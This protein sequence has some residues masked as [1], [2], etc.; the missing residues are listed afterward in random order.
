MNRAHKD[1]LVASSLCLK[2][3]KIREFVGI[4]VEVTESENLKSLVEVTESDNLKS[5]VE[6]DMDEQ[7]VDMDYTSIKMLLLIMS[8]LEENPGPASENASFVG[9]KELED[10]E[11]SEIKDEEVSVLKNKRSKCAVCGIGDLRPVL[12]EKGRQK[13]I[14]YTRNGM[15]KVTHQVMRCNNRNPECRAFHGFGFYQSKKHRIYENDALKNDVLVIS[16]QTGFAMDYLVEIAAA[17]EINADPF[18][19]LSKVYNRMH[20]NKLPTSTADRRIDLYQKRLTEAYFLYIYLELSQRYELPNHQVLENSNLDKTIMKHLQQLHK[21]FRNKW[22]KN[23]CDQKGCGW[24][25]TVDGGLKPHRMVCGAKLSG[26]REF[27]KAGIKVITGCTKHPAFNSKYCQEHQTE[28]SPAVTSDMISSRTRQQLRKHRTD[29]AI[30]SEAK[31]DDVFIVES[32]LE[33]K[34]EAKKVL[35]KWMGF[36][37][38]TWENEKGIPLFIRDYYEKDATRLGRYFLPHIYH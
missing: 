34:K 37:D 13:M 10:W 2:T 29:T 4:L 35:V 22:A 28:K 30:Y 15:K 18:E 17:I 38:A 14:V 12:E 36:P 7:G 27:P 16:A 32:I 23:Q 5:L 25:I 8:G 6:K 20:N 19:G 1:V 11:M 33:I 9:Q 31:Q 26:V 3:K 24:C 21:I